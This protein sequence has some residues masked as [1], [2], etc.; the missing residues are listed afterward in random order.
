M[1]FPDHIMNQCELGMMK[2]KNIM[3]NSRTEET[4]VGRL[5]AV[6]S[7][8]NAGRIVAL[9]IAGMSSQKVRLHIKQRTFSGANA[10]EHILKPNTDAARAAWSR[11]KDV[12]R[13]AGFPIRR[14]SWI[15]RP[16]EDLFDMNQS[17]DPMNI[18]VTNI[19]PATILYLPTKA[20]VEFADS[21]LRKSLDDVI[22][23]EAVLDQVD[24]NFTKVGKLLKDNWR[25]I[26]TRNIA[27]WFDK[28]EDEEK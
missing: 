15:D 24:A 14:S 21:Q 20:D 3:M 18:H 27:I 2:G 22:N 28:K 8:T 9:Y 25:E 19:N 11:G 4:M 6:S 5:N 23:R 1:L 12:C 10:I 16:N 7:A 13:A 17:D 26:T